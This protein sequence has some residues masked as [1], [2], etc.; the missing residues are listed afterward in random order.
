MSTH[1]GQERG[2]AADPT[3]ANEKLQGGPQVITPSVAADQSVPSALHLGT[4]NII[5][6]LAQKRQTRFIFFSLYFKSAQLSRPEYLCGHEHEVVQD[7]RGSLKRAPAHASEQVRWRHVGRVALPVVHRAVGT[8]EGGQ[9]TSIHQLDV[10]EPG[11]QVGQHD[12]TSV[13]MSGGEPLTDLWRKSKF[14][15]HFSLT[16]KC[17]LYLLR[18]HT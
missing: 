14:I 17:S 16:P 11:K 7:H 4:G 5:S 18:F 10:T 6:I 9:Q 13:R 1:M 3:Q 2:V 12:L 15:A 8:R